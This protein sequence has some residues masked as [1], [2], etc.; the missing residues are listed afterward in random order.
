M[1]TYTKET[2]MEK[3]KEFHSVFGKVP[4]AR[5]LKYT[6]GYPIPETVNRH[7][8]SLHQAL[9]ESG[10][11]E[12]KNTS[13]Q[14][15]K[16]YTRED[17]LLAIKQFILK[18]NKLPNY[19][20]FG[21]NSGLP[22]HSVLYRHFTSLLDALKEIGYEPKYKKLYKTHKVNNKIED[23]ELLDMLYKFF[24]KLERCPTMGDLQFNDELPSPTTYV[25]RFGKWTTALELAGIPYVKHKV[26]SPYSRDKTIE[27]WYQLKNKLNKIPTM[28]EIE[29]SEINITSSIRN[30]WGS[31]TEFLEAINEEV[32]FNKYGC[33]I[34]F[35]TKGTKCFS[36]MEYKLTEW[37]ENMDIS[38]EKD[39]PYSDIFPND[40][41]RRTVDWVINYDNKVYYVELFGIVNEEKYTEKMKRKIEDFKKGGIELIELYGK[42]VMKDKPEKIFSFLLK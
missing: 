4:T 21:G 2:I 3:L 32:N 30:K 10:L 34:Q 19:L 18:N 1:I 39:F 6:K 35:T 31:Y 8:G 22:S 29:T 33:K 37:L 7:M 12:E 26:E 28:W 36:A 42:N 40:E 27:I 16:K 17:L 24:L 13:R 11:I 38:F 23:K 25:S 5:D 9:F 15:K 41:S 14:V 20:D